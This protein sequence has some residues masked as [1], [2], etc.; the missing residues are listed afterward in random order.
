MCV[1][2]TS[3]IWCA[4][5]VYQAVCSQCTRSRLGVTLTFNSSYFVVVLGIRDHTYIQML[6]H[7]PFCDK[8]KTCIGFHSK[9]KSKWTSRNIRGREMVH[10]SD[11]SACLHS[12]VQACSGC[13]GHCTMC[14]HSPC[15]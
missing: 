3:M 6:K 8:E 1:L 15:T 10:T 2:C 5:P 12:A 11:M 4:D 13:A 14:G 7:L 9:S